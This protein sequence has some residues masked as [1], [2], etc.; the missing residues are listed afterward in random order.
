MSIG[1]KLQRLRREDFIWVIY[2]FIA[3]MALVSDYYERQFLFSKNK[4]DQNKFRYINMG[5]AI[6]ACFIYLYFI[7]INYEDITVLRNEATKKEVIMTHASFIAALL[8]LLGGIITLF[9]EF[10]R[11]DELP[12]I[13]LP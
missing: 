1:V 7:L 2:L 13:G 10:N 3:I 9:V 4:Q 6:V 5:I 11:G 12:D 8:F